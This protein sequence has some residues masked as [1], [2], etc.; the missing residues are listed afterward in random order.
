[1]NIL[2]REFSSKNLF[3]FEI[4]NVFGVIGVVECIFMVVYLLDRVYKVERRRI[5]KEMGGSLLKSL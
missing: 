5:W 2:V 3:E 4:N 1:M